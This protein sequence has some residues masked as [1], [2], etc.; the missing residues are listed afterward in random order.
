MRSGASKKE[1]GKAVLFSPAYNYP[2]LE[3]PLSFMEGEE[4]RSRA[5]SKTRED[6]SPSLSPLSYSYLLLIFTSKNVEAPFEECKREVCSSRGFFALNVPRGWNAN[7]WKWFT[8][9]R[10]RSEG[11]EWIQNRGTSLDDSSSSLFIPRAPRIFAAWPLSFFLGLTGTSKCQS[12]RVSS[13]S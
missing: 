12:T 5:L 3:S 11:N 2:V 7:P 8:E 10:E 13:M 1:R 4:K 9:R 6:E